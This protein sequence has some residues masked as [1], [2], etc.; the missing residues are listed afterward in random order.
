MD[1]AKDE[2]NALADT[3]DDMGDRIENAAQDPAVV[4]AIARTVFSFGS[5][6]RAAGEVYR[7]YGEVYGAM[8]EAGDAAKAVGDAAQPHFSAD[9]GAVEERAAA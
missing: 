5:I 8:G 4:D 2:M 6:F 3:C 1:A 9:D 7:A